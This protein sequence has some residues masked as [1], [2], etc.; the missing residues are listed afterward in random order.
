MLR[1]FIALLFILASC[2][3]VAT[4]AYA[5]TDSMTVYLGGRPNAGPVAG[6]PGSTVTIPVVVTGTTGTV[7]SGGIEITVPS[8][9]RVV[10]TSSC[11]AESVAARANATVTMRP[12]RIVGCDGP[13]GAQIISAQTEGIGCA[14]RF[15]D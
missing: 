12:C 13:N 9:L 15:Q 4:T 2:T 5:Q 8:P 3:L 1:T 7:A 14:F 11:T 10:N 6:A